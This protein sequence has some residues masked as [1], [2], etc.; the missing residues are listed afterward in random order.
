LSRGHPPGSRPVPL[1]RHEQDASADHHRFSLPQSHRAHALGEGRAGAPGPAPDSPTGGQPATKDQDLVAT[2]RQSLATNRPPASSWNKNSPRRGTTLSARDQGLADLQAEKAKLA[3]TLTDEQRTAQE[4]TQSAA[5]AK[6]ESN[7]TRDQ[8]AQLQ[9]ELEEKRALADRQQQAIAKL[10]A[11]SANAR[12]QIEGLT[13]AVVVGESE[14]QHLQEQTAQLTTQ[15]QAERARPPE[16]PGVHQSAGRRRRR[17]GREFRRAHQG[18]P[19]QPADQRQRPVQQFPRRPR[20][21]DLHRRAQGPVRRSRFAK[22]AP[23]PSSSAMGRRS[24]PCSTWRTRSSPP[25]KTITTGTRSRR[26]RPQRRPRP[27]RRAGILLRPRVVVVPVDPGQVAQSAPRSIRSRPDPLKFSDAVLIS[28]AKGMAN[29]PSASIRTCPATSASTIA[30]SS[31][32]SVTSPPRA[33]IWCSVTPCELLGIMVNNDLLRP[34]EGN[35]APLITIKTGNDTL[36]GAHRRSAWTSSAPASGPCPRTCSKGRRASRAAATVAA[37]PARGAATRRG[38]RPR[39]SPGAVR[40]RREAHA[41]RAG[42]RP[43]R[44]PGRVPAGGGPAVH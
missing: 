22:K 26:V 34:A 23:R 37:A 32:S 31:G 14:K 20:R 2:M 1:L 25:G 27:G 39:A 5:A 7:L 18:D 41:A 21:H 15:V 10:E 38:G 17:I 16:G 30:F 24:M 36:A 44:R 29:C 28:G 40:P 33:A 42:G 19:R 4:L 6:E 13:L 35:F 3:A 9:R 8:L 11:D 43:D 12:K